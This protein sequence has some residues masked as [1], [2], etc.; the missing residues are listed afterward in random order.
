[1]KEVLTK[2][3]D[4]LT[5][6]DLHGALKKLLERYNKW[7]AAGL[8]FHVCNIN[9]SAHMKKSLETYLMIL[10]YIYIYIYI[11]EGSFNNELEY[12]RTFLHGT[13][14]AFLLKLKN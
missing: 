11:Y 5:Q 1:M 10:V 9:K 2:V 12:S 13:T 3:I 7:I 8:E 6:G 4:T 14:Q